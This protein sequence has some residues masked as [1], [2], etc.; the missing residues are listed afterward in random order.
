MDKK[1]NTEF[2]SWKWKKENSKPERTMKH[3]KHIFKDEGIFIEREQNFMDE[4]ILAQ[5]GFSLKVSKKQEQNDKL[6]D[7]GLMIQKS[8][9]PFLAKN[10]YLND[11]EKEEKFLRPS[12]SNF[13]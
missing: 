2:V 5:S 11:L 9:N 4:S 3:E 1:I 10:N 13:E 8:V 12:D 7:R 6:F